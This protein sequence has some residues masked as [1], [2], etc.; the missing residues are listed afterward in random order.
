MHCLVAIF[1]AA[2]IAL[3]G[4]GACIPHHDT[5]AVATASGFTVLCGPAARPEGIWEFIVLGLTAAPLC[6]CL[7]STFVG[8]A[9]MKQKA[10]G[11]IPHHDTVTVATASKSLLYWPALWPGPKVRRRLMYRGGLPRTSVPSIDRRSWAE[12]ASDGKLKDV[13]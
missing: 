4:R 7:R 11:A 6:A 2:R 3:F 12:P 8:G 10:N 13:L 9:R 1:V 5:L